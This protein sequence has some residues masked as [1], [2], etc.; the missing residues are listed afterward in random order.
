MIKS[1]LTLAR[2]T[3]YILHSAIAVHP[4]KPC[5]S[6]VRRSSCKCANRGHKLDGRVALRNNKRRR[7]GIR[8]VYPEEVADS[9]KIYN[10]PQWLLRK[11]RKMNGKTCT[12][13]S[14]NTDWSRN[15]CDCPGRIDLSYLNSNPR[16]SLYRSM[17]HKWRNREDTL[18]IRVAFYQH[19]NQSDRTSD[20]FLE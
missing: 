4:G 18:R 7:I 8:N 15:C 13:R 11:S 20:M 10:D 19:R 14:R 16:C 2:K 6:N 1:Y 17:W 9:D 5:S 3:I 12:G